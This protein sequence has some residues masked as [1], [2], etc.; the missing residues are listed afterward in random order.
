MLHWKDKA[1]QFQQ[2]SLQLSPRTLQQSPNASQLVL[3]NESDSKA[4]ILEQSSASYF[5][6]ELRAVQAQYSEKLRALISQCTQQ[7]NFGTMI[8][9]N[10]Y[11]FTSASILLLLLVYYTVYEYIYE[12]D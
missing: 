6:K 8:L 12:Y 10:F 7:L 5:E 1:L 3:H 2:Q 11:S 4:S 9:T